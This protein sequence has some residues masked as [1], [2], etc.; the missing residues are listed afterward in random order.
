M[1]SSRF[2]S[3]IR[4]IAAAM[5]SLV[6]AWAQAAPLVID[7]PAQPLITSIQQLS[8]QSGL[9]IGGNAALL[10]GKTA[11]AVHGTLEPADALRKLLQGS[12]LS[13]DFD[14][15]KAVIRKAA[16][17]LLKEVVVSSDA[18]AIPQE[19][20]A[21]A[22]YKPETTK[23]TGPWG[24]KP[25]LDTPY[26]IHSTSSE[27]MENMISG[28][29]DNV[30]KYNPVVQQAA[31]PTNGYTGHYI[32]GYS[33]GG[34]A[35]RDGIPVYSSLIST[36]EDVERIEVLSG[37]SGFLYGAGNVGGLVNFVSKR[38]T[39]TPI[40]NI[41]AG[42]HGGEQYFAHVDAGG[43]MDKEGK[44]GY[45]LNAAF[46]EGDTAI[47]DQSTRRKLLSAAFDWHITDN[48]LVQLDFSHQEYHIS[49]VSGAVGMWGLKQLPSAESMNNR[50]ALNPKWTFWE[51][52]NDKVGAALQWAVDESLSIRSSYNYL[53]NSERQRQGTPWIQADGSVYQAYWDRAR[54]G[55]E[56]HS[57]YVYADK[58]FST[59]NVAHKL[60]FG[61]NYNSY[62]LS[63]HEDWNSYNETL[64]PNLEAALNA[65]AIDWPAIGIKPYY[66]EKKYTNQNWLIGDEITFNDQWMILAGLNHSN[67]N[68]RMY[69]PA[70]VQISQYNKSANTPSA[71]I[72]YKPKSNITTY[73]SYLESLEAGPSVP[74]DPRYTNAGQ[75][76]SPTISKQLEVGAKADLGKLLLTAALFKI[77]RANSYTQYHDNGSMTID[78]NGRQEHK[79]IELTATGKISN[80]LTVYGGG[81]FVDATVKKTNTPHDQGRRPAAVANRKLSMYA[82]YR[83]RKLNGIYLTGGFSHVG[84]INLKDTE[85]ISG[86]RIDVPS[87]TVVD[88]GLRYETRFDGSPLIARLSVSNVT[89]KHYWIVGAIGNSFMLGAPRTVSFSLTRKF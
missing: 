70:G 86:H 78:Q 67:I 47:N 24:D 59:A 75:V 56:N 14:G 76:L 64:F 83:V 45:R 89:N 15:N 44:F 33:S 36:I 41:T 40:L 62:D 7:L 9:S 46:T 5:L 31:P 2:I 42:N 16:S 63:Y 6:A 35:A 72:I 27:L 20:S 60:T 11:P 74:S 23:T 21:E 57:A 68:T 77:N 13:V 66:I 55:A 4:P 8:R 69:N 10:E 79:G 1:P 52:E 28:S 48:L 82:E 3:P 84:S 22:G 19:G 30:I 37:L 81:T 32:R 43:P 29:T 49:G 73:V 25:V 71:S 39:A 85:T 65:P 88:A 51:T 17:V 38:P 87:Y 61:A 50:K 80:R 26:S 53:S 34:A 18:V 58:K 54:S 12:G